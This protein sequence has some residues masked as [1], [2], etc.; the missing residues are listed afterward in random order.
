MSG[1]AK[2]RFSVVIQD[3]KY[4]FGDD[5]HIARPP[6][7]VLKTELDWIKKNYRDHLTDLSAIVPEQPASSVE[8]LV[9]G[10]NLYG[11]IMLSD[12]VME[13]LNLINE[14]EALF[15]TLNGDDELVASLLGIV[16][17]SI[18]VTINQHIFE[19]TNGDKGLA[20]YRYVYTLREL[21]NSRSIIEAARYERV[22]AYMEQQQLVAAIIESR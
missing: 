17:R 14:S 7:S 19:E 21:L 11:T 2:K 4:N 16:L 22:N 5:I 13:T 18:T 20:N 9:K 3:I 10:L 1:S 8:R 15:K 6:K 12:V